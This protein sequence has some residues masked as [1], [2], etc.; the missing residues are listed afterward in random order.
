VQVGVI[1]DTHSLLRPQVLEVFRGVD[2]ILHAGDIGSPEILSALRRIGAVRAIRGN[3][4]TAP[5]AASIPE[6]AIVRLE[7]VTIYLIHDF[8]DMKLKPPA[9][10]IDVVISGHSHRPLID[11]R[12]GLLLINPGSAGPRRFKLPISVARLT[13]NGSVVRPELIELSP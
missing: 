1:S 12:D 5:W 9:K 11:R 10:P 3:N 8:K 4:D 7:D 6:T 2:W 13:I